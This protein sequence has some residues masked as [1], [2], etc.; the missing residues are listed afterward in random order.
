MGR[1]Y[2]VKHSVLAT[3]WYGMRQDGTR[4]DRREICPGPESNRHGV[5]PKGF[6]YPLQLSLLRA[7]AHL[8]SG[9]YLCPVAGVDSCEL[10]RGRQVSTLSRRL[11]ACGLSSV[12]QPPRRAAGSPTL[13]PFTPAVSAPGAQIASSPLRLPISPPGHGLPAILQNLGPV[14]RCWIRVVALNN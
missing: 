8:G 7:C 2:P 3:P 6:S 5:A 4:W 12:L 9:L 14:P 13:T 1:R 10:G 11:P